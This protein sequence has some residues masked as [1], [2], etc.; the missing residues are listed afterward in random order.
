[1]RILL[2]YGP[3]VLVWT[4]LVGL[5]LAALAPA[6]AQPGDRLY[7]ESGVIVFATPA[8]QHPPVQA[9]VSLPPTP[10]ATEMPAPTEPAPVE[11]AAP[12]E[13][14]V[15]YIDRVV[16]VPV[17]QPAPVY[18]PP[19][20][21]EVI[22]TAAPVVEA[23]PPQPA[24]DTGNVARDGCPFPV[25]NGVCGDGSTAPKVT[26]EGARHSPERHIPDKPVELPGGVLIVP[27]GQPEG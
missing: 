11:V 10:T 25:I 8:V 13:P 22:P 3:R 14:Q 4:L 15:I 26:E 24:P 17:E 12:P 19:P 27:T 20:P 6:Y 5:G 1:M 23:A 18:Q 7:L 21:A 16:E 2:A 9:L